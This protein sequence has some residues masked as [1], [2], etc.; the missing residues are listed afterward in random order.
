MTV[1]RS[2]SIALRRVGGAAL[3][4]V[5]VAGGFALLASQAAGTSQA[6]AKSASPKEGFAPDPQ[7]VAT[8]KQW[9]FQ[10]AVKESVPTLGSVT[11]VELK[12]ATAT[13]RVMGRFAVEFIVG[14]ELLDR[15]RFDVPLNGDGPRD[16]DEA[17]RKRPSF[18]VN[19]KMFVRLADHE[20][21]TQVRLVD[22]ATGETT[23]FLWPPNAD[24]TLT[25]VEP[26]PVASASASTS[27][28]ASSSSA[29]SGPP[30]AK[31]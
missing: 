3:L 31:P 17:G 9:V 7:P 29:P 19:T 26:P 18:R 25:K 15:H 28:S 2:I 27:A 22:R 24:G 30:S 8:K 1:A 12:Q 14:T 23:R 16:R 6:W 5:V 21:A 10:I 13:P 11:E 4:G 20:R